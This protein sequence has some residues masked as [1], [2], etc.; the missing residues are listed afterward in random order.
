MTPE[1]ITVLGVLLVAVILFV[2]EKLRVDIV[3]LLMLV[4]LAVTGLVEPKEALSG[5]SNPAV[6]TVIFVFIL[7]AGL[8]RSGIAG[9]LGRQVLRLAAGGELALVVLI[10]LTASG[11][12]AFMNNVGVAALMLPVVMDIARRTR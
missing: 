9:L 7:S 11:L 3:A 4:T 10:M 8:A 5:F 2:T 6:I 12:S 1:I